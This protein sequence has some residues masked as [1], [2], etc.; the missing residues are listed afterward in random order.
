MNTLTT[1]TTVR[2]ALNQ[3]ANENSETAFI[4]LLEA[5][6]YRSQRR[7]DG[8]SGN[9]HDFMSEFRADNIGT[10]SEQAFQQDATDVRILFQITDDEIGE[11]LQG[12]LLGSE[13][14]DEG[15]V[16]SFVFVAIQLV[17]KSYPRGRYVAFT[18]EINKRF[19]GAPAVVVFRTAD[20][21]LTLAFVNR[22]PSKNNPDR[23]VLGNVSLIREVDAGDPHRA[24]LDILEEL[25]L[26]NLLKWIDSRSRKRN[27]D[28]L[29]EAWLDALNTDALNKRFYQ[30]LYAWFQRAIG[31]ATFPT[32]PIKTL[33]PEEHVIRLITRLLFVW[34][35]KEKGL[36]AE[37]LFVENQ[38]SRLLKDYDPYHGDSYYRAVLQNLFFATLNTEI[39]QRQFSQR[40]NTTHRLFSR[41]RYADEIADREGLLS[42]LDKTPF[43][44]GGLFDCL[45]SEEASGKGG[46]RIDCFTDNPRHRGGYSIPNRLFFD[47]DANNPG[48]ITLFNRYKFT[49]EE[50][51]PAEQEVA[52]D[53]ELLGKVFE[54]LLAAYNPETKETARKQTGSYYTPRAVVDYM[55]DEALIAVL[56]TKVC[57]NDEAQSSWKDRLHYLL[58]YGDAFDDADELFSGNEKSGV[59]EAIAN[60]RVLDP[61]VGSG[62]FPMG[63]LHKL[64]LAL[65]R[66]DAENALWEELQKVKAGE[67]AKQAFNTSE[68]SERDAELA[69]ISA[70]F[71]HYRGSDYG[72]KLYLIQNSIFGVDIQSVATQIAKLRFFISLAIEQSPTKE[73]DENYGIRPLPNLET[74]FVAADALRGIGNSIQLTLGQT[75]EVNDLLEQ[76]NAN[77]ERHFHANTRSEKLACRRRD[78]TTRRELAGALAVAGFAA[79]DA[80]KLSTWDPY[81]QHASADWFDPEYMFGVS[82]GFDVVIGNPPYIQLQKNA[83]RLRKLY[84]H[85]G[86]ETFASTGDIYQLFYE[87]GCQLLVRDRGFLAYITSN[88]WLRA[89]Y[90]KALRR[91]LGTNLTPMALL[92]LGKDVFEAVIV[93]ASVLLVRSGRSADAARSFASVDTDKLAV[94]SFPPNPQVWQRTRIAG[95]APWSILSNLELSILDKMNDKGTPLKEWDISIN[96]GIKTGLNEAFIIDNETK[97]ELVAFDPKSTEIL[98]PVVRGRDIRRFHVDW[99]GLW[100][101]ATF[102]S[103]R[104]D[105]DKYPA[106]RDYLLGFGRDRLTQAGM[107]LSDGRRSRKKTDN[108]WFELQD[109]C[110]YHADFSKEKLLWI[111]LVHEGRFAYDDGG[112]FGEATTFMLTG[113]SIKFLCAV[114][115]T[116]LIRWCLEKQAPTSGMGTLRWKKVYVEQLPIPRISFLEQ[117]FFVRAIDRILKFD[118]AAAQTKVDSSQHAINERVYHLYGLTPDEIA[119]VAGQE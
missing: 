84:Q 19:R 103:A 113:E 45:D 80:A 28:G 95:D 107:T 48:L 73:R 58:D 56:T 54:N 30:D 51:T 60:L 88:S 11:T 93:D 106:V 46:Y 13:R 33:S 114:L 112:V 40:S 72:R 31:E 63:V 1:K 42:L 82:E 102:P 74:R 66:L 75:S 52:L 89:E 17:Q 67:R 90:G 77:R 44:N 39:G 20:G 23:Q 5:L 25:E 91:Y 83:G 47:E 43:I 100:L 27:F 69:E 18:R 85:Q 101:I 92:D 65:R 111:E 108:A 22:R 32:D 10:G 53:P 99:K 34:F 55:V 2:S 78:V 94:K 7:L 115:N 9:V 29:L 68:Q 38:V 49:V 109:S 64:T 110:A 14:F 116:K 61:A 36:V 4:G 50:N 35:I 104:L 71:E 16:R 21:R 76:L 86:F 119:E 79:E 87:R 70:T 26:P 37:D 118:S 41:Y 117:E 81:D 62:A 105:I 6:G 98:K 8:Q 59:V 3:L 96:Y 15:N 24:H 57:R 97:E 12:G